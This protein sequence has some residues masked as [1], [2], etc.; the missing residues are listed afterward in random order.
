MKSKHTV[1]I[2]AGAIFLSGCNLFEPALYRTCEDAFKERLKSP[3][4]YKRISVSS[5]KNSAD[6]IAFF[7]S[8]DIREEGR[9]DIYRKAWALSKPSFIRHHVTFTYDAK[10]T[11]GA[12]LRG[13]FEC[14]YY[15]DKETA[16]DAASYDVVV[17]GKTNLEWLAS[18][19]S[20]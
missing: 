20:N 12:E 13:R 3:S 5:E 14:E 2:M 8:R 17:D 10:N 18:R 19:T 7:L 6:E 4:S 15:S 9:R 11:F 16:A 1:L